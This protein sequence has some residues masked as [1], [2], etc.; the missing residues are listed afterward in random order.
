MG[1]GGAARR[2]PGAGVDQLRRESFQTSARDEAEAHLR[3]NYGDVALD[4]ERID[5]SERLISHPDFS[6]VDLEVSGEYRAAAEVAGVT[7]AA[8]DDGYRWQVGD[9]RGTA[10]EP[11][12]FQPGEPLSCRVRDARVRVIV[13]PLEPLTALARTVYNDE[14][15]EVR[16]DSGH[17]VSPALLRA[18]RAVAGAAF[19]AAP[20]LGNDLIR[21]TIFRSLAVTTLEAFALSG[22]RP[23]RSETA[24]S[25]RAAYRRALTF[26][27]DHASL[28]VTVDDAA[29]AAGVSAAALI[30]AFQTYAV[31]GRAPGEY[32]AAVRRDAARHD[33]AAIDPGD[34]AAVQVVADRWGVT[35][36]GLRAHRDRR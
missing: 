28:P 27:D 34:G 19:D 3:R 2:T 5:Y 30:R 10:D 21:A 13:L 32:L 24:R 4:A 35:V 7:I 22:D 20:S 18:W 36:R 1:S 8:G 16:F 9:A 14:S 6:L 29:A 26:F 11:V 23:R 12:L 33:L 15:L 25:Q 31:G 17:P